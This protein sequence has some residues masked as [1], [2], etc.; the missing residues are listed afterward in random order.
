MSVISRNIWPVCGSLC[1]FCPALR[2][3]SRHPI[4]RYKKFLADIFPRTPDEEPNERMIGK[5][6]EYASKNPLRVPKITSYLEQRCYREL[7]TENYQSV[8]VVI[9]I[10]RKLL[11][12]CK[13]QMPLFASSLLSIIQIL[14][15]QPRHDEVQILGCQTLFDFVNNQRDGTYMFNLDGFI[16]KLC[17]LAQEMGDDAKVQHLRAAGL[18][19]LSSMVWFMGEFTHISAEFDNVV[20]VVLE[21]YGD[22][23]EDS[24]NENAMRLYSWRMVVNDRGEVNV[25]VD[26]ATN[27]GFWSRVCIQNMA[28]LA[29][30]GT[31]VRRVLESL[32]RYFDNTNLWS[33]EHGLALS[34]LLNMQS[35][36]E[37]SGH[38]THLLLSILVKHLDHKNVLKNPKMQLDIVGVITHLAQQTRV[39]Q[40]VAIIGALSDMMRHL[41]KSI[42]CSLDDSNLGSEIIQWN[43]KYRMEVD[44]C[45]VQLTIKIA[46]AGP[47]IDT[48][49]VLLENMSNITVMA[50]TLIAAVYR[51]AQ[52]V[53][54]IPNLSYQNKAFPEAL[55][56]QLLLAMVHADHETRVGAHRI[57]SVV[58]VPSSV[59]PQPSSSGTPMTH[60]ADIQR[61]LSRNV[62]VFS[63]SSALFEKL[64]RKQNSLPEDSHADGNVNDNSILN[65][66]KSTYSRTTSTRKS[67]LTSAEYTDNRNSKVHNSSMMS[68]LKSSYSRATSVKKPQIPTTVE[69]NTTNTSN[70]QQVLPIRLSSHQITLL[71]SSIWAQSIYPLNTSENFEA[72]AHTYSLVLLVARSKNSSHEAL[73]QSFQLA[74]SLRNISLNE[75]VKLQPS[76]RRSLFTLATSMII[77]AS[78]AYNILSLIS[79]AKTTLTDRTVDPFLQL[80]N[81]SKL[82]AVTD[83]DKQPSKVYGSKE[84]DEDALKSLSAIKLTESQSKESFATMIV[85]S[86]GKSSNESSILRERLLNDF[87]PDDAC[88]LGAQ[89]S[90]ETTGN[91]Y[92]SGLKE[93]KL[94]DMVDISLFTIDDD[95]PP[96]GLESQANSDSMQQPSQNL[97]LLSVD[98]ILGSVSETTHQV[99]RISISTPFDMPYK[100]MALHC[101]ALL[102]GK[103]QKMST[104]M[105]T[106]PMQGYSFRI[107]APE[108]YQQKDESS[109]SS[110]QQTLSSSGNPFLDSNFDSNSHNTLPDTA[111]RLCA[112]AYQHQAAFFQ[113]PASRPYDNF[114]KAAGC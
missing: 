46:D 32:F 67:A 16:L 84:D 40:S 47:V 80:V 112:T 63:S 106:L 69:E 24:Q 83:T 9:C 27:P 23:K 107:P 52:I 3:R 48:M 7:R 102:V 79:I 98:D 77:F 99:G 108:Y 71:L 38:N 6:C 54:S 25:P 82:Q 20:S 43:Q 76:R 57:F 109:N 58:L 2:E 114:L 65:R 14:L 11:I 42:H 59:C 29:K 19:V 49:A 75:N 8:K 51:T 90:A 113:L 53:A 50:R 111:P 64:E 28:K 70:K 101:E 66:L 13:D 10:Y 89:L 39:Q 22:V 85:Q 41:R 110:V 12:S 88:P 44:E 103:Q 26:N 72:I 62:S 30:E 17:N 95:I 1:C 81:D 96:C 92:Q 100:E 15:D 36:I 33:P 35:I 105:G 86:L 56:H 60:A 45:L 68:R 21:N 93:D 91:M 37:N 31:T 73:T 61:M 34:V 55:F 74:F 97:S 78:K 87:S 18:Q 104:F 94:P 4:K 5:L